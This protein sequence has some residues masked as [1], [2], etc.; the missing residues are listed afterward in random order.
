MQSAVTDEEELDRM[1]AGGTG[2][3]KR[4]PETSLAAS[5]TLLLGIYL[6]GMKTSV[7]TE[8]SNRNVHSSFIHNSQTLETGCLSTSEGLC[9]R[10]HIPIVGCGPPGASD[11][12]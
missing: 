11:L 2:K 5:V 1:V 7:E 9:P 4:H 6:K 10:R 12:P 8:T 3:W